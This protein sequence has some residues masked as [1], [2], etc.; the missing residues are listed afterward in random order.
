[1]GLRD[2]PFFVLTLFYP[3]SS[4]L[5]MGMAHFACQLVSLSGI[6]ECVFKT[7]GNEQKRMACITKKNW[8]KY[9]CSKCDQ[10]KQHLF[11]SFFILMLCMLLRNKRYISCI[12][13]IRKMKARQ[14]FYTTTKKSLVKLYMDTYS[15]KKTTLI[16]ISEHK[17]SKITLLPCYF[18]HVLMAVNGCTAKYHLKWV[19]NDAQSIET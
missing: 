18:L 14:L 16:D 15:L 12:Y 4:L 7:E 2:T 6:V 3:G 11:S 8:E 5:Q 19:S 1:M 17:M 13:P 10:V 9:M